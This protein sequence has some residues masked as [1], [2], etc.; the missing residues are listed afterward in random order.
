MSEVT[1]GCE[2]HRKAARFRLSPNF[3]VMEWHDFV[4]H[5]VTTVFVH[6]QQVCEAGKW[7]LC[8]GGQILID[9]SS[10]KKRALQIHLRS[11]LLLSTAAQNRHGLFN[12]LF[13]AIKLG[14]GEEFSQGDIQPI[15]QFFDRH[16]TGV[17]A[18]AV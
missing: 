6:V 12:F 17:P 1:H 16:R 15:A 9:Y 4:N 7:T 8:T 5:I 13:Q 14:C 10:T 11:P 2:P 3:R 18:F